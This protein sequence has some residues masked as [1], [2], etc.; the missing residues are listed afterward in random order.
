M[1]TKLPAS[2][3]LTSHPVDRCAEITRTHTGQKL[4]RLV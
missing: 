2:Q 4:V 1:L 3:P